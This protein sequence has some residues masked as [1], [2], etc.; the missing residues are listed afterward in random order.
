MKSA[1]RARSRSRYP[2][3]RKDLQWQP[4]RARGSRVSGGAGAG[5]CGG[6]LSARCGHP[7]QSSRDRTIRDRSGRRPSVWYRVLG[8]FG[9]GDDFEKLGI[10]VDAANILG[11]SGAG[12]VDAAGGARLRV[13]GEEL[14]E[15][16]DVLPVVAEVVDV[17][18]TE[19]F[20]AIEVKEADGALIEAARI[21]LEFG[22]ANLGIAIGQTADP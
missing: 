8:I 22:L 1:I 4:I 17:K 12:A 9:V 14:L 18:K 10:A 20:V 3:T 5:G 13:E 7:C 19:V 2:A 11:R 15:F 16:D 21:A 6:W